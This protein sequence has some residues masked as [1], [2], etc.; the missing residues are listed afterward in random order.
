MQIRLI[1]HGASRWERFLR[2]WG[3]SFLIDDDILF[4]TFGDPMVLLNNIRKFN[5]DVAKI[6]YIVLS[7]DDW[8]HIAGL[9][10]LLPNRKDM[11]VYICPG[12][13]Q[14]I[15][16]KITSFGINVIEAKGIISIKDGIYS[17]GELFGESGTRR[18]FEQSLVVKGGSGLAVVCGCAHPGILNIVKHVKNN[19]QEDVYA[20][21]GGFHLKES[22]RREIYDIIIKIKELNIKR[23]IPAHCT[24][25]L[26]ITKFKQQFSEDFINVKEGSVIEV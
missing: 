21:V 10:Y 12:F 1:A 9:W 15:K 22:T 4:D 6:K 20:L 14:E 13:Q 3:I 17:T 18:I 24:G 25:K 11:T 2:K 23:V 26:A 7:H 16:K 5:I 8:D 19:F